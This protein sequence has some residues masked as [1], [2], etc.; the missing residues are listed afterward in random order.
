MGRSKESEMIRETGEG[1]GLESSRAGRNRVVR[2][3]RGRNQDRHRRRRVYIGGAPDIHRGGGKT[4]IK[5]EKKGGRTR[6]YRERKE[7]G[8]SRERKK[9]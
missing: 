2:L 4:Q 8:T 1:N 7:K 6:A 5:R 9:E 3:Q